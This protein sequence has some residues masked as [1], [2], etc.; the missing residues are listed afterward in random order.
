MITLIN[1]HEA[2]RHADIVDAMFRGRAAIFREK[3]GWD[4]NVEDGRECDPYD[5]LNPLYVIAL[6]DETGS[7]I[8]SIRLMP[9]TGPT[10]QR[11]IF[12]NAFDD[13]VDL[14]SATIWEATRFCVHPQTIRRLTPTRLDRATCEIAIA[15]CEIGLNAGLTQYIGIFEPHMQRIYRRI[16]WEPEVLARSTAFETGPIAVGL[17]DVTTDALADIR[18]R[19]GIYEDIIVDGARK[20]ARILAKAA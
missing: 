8:G 1:G 9:T 19:A 12:A 2:D 13:D 17:W 5:A 20:R 18:R 6:D 4:V 15:M 10:L 11:D 16:G 3:L 14:V 7:V